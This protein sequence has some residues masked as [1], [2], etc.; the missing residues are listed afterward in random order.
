MP[1]LREEPP[2]ELLRHHDRL[3]NEPETRG[4]ELT[5]MAALI[6]ITQP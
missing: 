2:C 1:G 4:S 5:Q 6:A 3:F